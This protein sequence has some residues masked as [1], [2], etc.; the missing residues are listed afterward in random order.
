MNCPIEVG[1]LV[2]IGGCAGEIIGFKHLSGSMVV[3]AV[4]GTYHYGKK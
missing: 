2:N 3:A 1:T 4:H